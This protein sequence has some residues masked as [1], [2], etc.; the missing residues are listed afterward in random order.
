MRAAAKLWR[1]HKEQAANEQHAQA[2]HREDMLAQADEFRRRN[3]SGRAPRIPR[4]RR[5]LD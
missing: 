3:P 1:E 4:K 5:V 2:V